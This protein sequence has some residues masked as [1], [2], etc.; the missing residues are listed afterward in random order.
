M[1]E[2]WIICSKCKRESV[3]DIKDMESKAVGK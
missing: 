1:T 3:M 2:K